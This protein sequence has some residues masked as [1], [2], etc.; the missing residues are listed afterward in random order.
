MILVLVILGLLSSIVTVSVIGLIT[1]GEE[2]GFEVDERV[3]QSS[4]AV[5]YAD[6]HQYAEGN[7]GWNE[8]GNYTSVH[9]Y[10]TQ[11]ARLSSLRTGKTTIVNGKEV[12]ELVNA[13][14]GLATTEE[15][16][17]AA[18]WIGLL[19]NKPSVR[20]PGDDIPPGSG[21]SPLHEEDGPYLQEVPESCSGLNH[22][23]K[24]GTYTW[25][26]GQY[27]RVYG[28]FFHG[29]RWYAGYNGF[30]P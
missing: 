5:F 22:R 26:V 8:E 14:G 1:R 28:V 24:D 27:G 2:E 3:V 17:E 4:V 21:N 7:G 16:T 29:G 15:V 25:I 11:T 9:N 18:V 12:K 10:P 20:T 13:G 23:L 6:V 19:T 30:Y